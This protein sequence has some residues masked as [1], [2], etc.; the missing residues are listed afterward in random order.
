ACQSWL[1]IRVERLPCSRYCA[2]RLWRS[3]SDNTSRRNTASS[4]G[5]VRREFCSVRTRSSVSIAEWV[6]S[7]S[8]DENDASQ[9]SAV[10]LSAR[11]SLVDRPNRNIG[12]AL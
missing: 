8:L 12:G 1:S 4:R 11:G 9:R 6:P 3:G 5:D 7:G 2:V 10:F